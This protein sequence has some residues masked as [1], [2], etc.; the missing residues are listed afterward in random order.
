MISYAFWCLRLTTYT[1]MGLWLNKV[2]HTLVWKN[3]SKLVNSKIL[4]FT[5]TKH[6][7]VFFAFCPLEKTHWLWLSINAL[8]ILKCNTF[9]SHVVGSRT[10]ALPPHTLPM[11]YRKFENA[12]RWAPVRISLDFKR[13]GLCCCFSF[14]F[15]AASAMKGWQALD[16]FLY[17]VIVI[18]NFTN[19]IEINAN[20]CFKIIVYTDRCLFCFSW[21]NSESTEIG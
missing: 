1:H 17:G 2:A 7:V 16:E 12:H 3:N 19:I 10:E 21:L 8:K 5:D 11:C 15:F 18:V 14:R 9:Q 13:H 4:N 6:Y 20:V